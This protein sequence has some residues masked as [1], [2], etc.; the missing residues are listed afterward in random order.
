MK[1][2]L[3]ILAMIVV[4][5]VV[6]PLWAL[7]TGA[8]LWLVLRT[9][10]WQQRVKYWRWQDEAARRQYEQETERFERMNRETK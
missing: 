5:V 7:V 3:T 1:Y 6:S 2:L 8:V 10:A 4:A 9:P